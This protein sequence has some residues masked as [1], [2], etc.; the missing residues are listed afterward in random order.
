MIQQHKPQI[1]YITSKNR[2]KNSLSSINSEDLLVLNQHENHYRKKLQNKSNV[3]VLNKPTDDVN[4]NQVEHRNKR[5]KLPNNNRV[6][7]DENHEALKQKLES[8]HQTDCSNKNNN[9]EIGVNF[10]SR[11][12][13]LRFIDDSAASAAST[14]VSS[15]V[16]FKKNPFPT[17]QSLNEMKNKNYLKSIKKESK[18][19]LSSLSSDSSTETLCSNENL[20][21]IVN[22]K[23]TKQHLKLSDYDNI[24]KEIEYLTSIG[25]SMKKNTS[26]LSHSQANCVP[27]NL[28]IAVRN[29]HRQRYREQSTTSITTSDTDSA[30]D[31]ELRETRASKKLFQ[32]ALA[33]MKQNIE[34]DHSEINDMRNKQ[35]LDEKYFR[36]QSSDSSSC[37]LTSEDV[38]NFDENGIIFEEDEEENEDDDDYNNLLV[39]DGFIRMY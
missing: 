6:I 37:E 32:K 27:S 10:V 23:E 28:K 35:G 36:R 9:N 1:N 21:V 38:V 15:P 16:E 20:H 3:S 7:I 11:I 22:N 18:I 5:I 2:G 33:K 17:Q 12:N 29:R 39:E 19:N 4:A 26:K 30:T 24:D 13:R 25:S 8:T 31:Q 14:T 34:S